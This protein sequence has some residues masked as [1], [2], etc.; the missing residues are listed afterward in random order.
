MR[1]VVTDCGLSFEG[2]WFNSFERTSCFQNVG[3][4]QPDGT[5]LRPTNSKPILQIYIAEPKNSIHYPLLC[6]A[7]ST[8]SSQIISSHNFLYKSDCK[9]KHARKCMN[10]NVHS[11]RN[12]TLRN[13]I[14]NFRNIPS[15]TCNSG[16]SRTSVRV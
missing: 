1:C 14:E 13:N 9:V 4:G 16:I 10:K 2:S 15:R 6:P 12:M 8:S 5:L 11:E 3:N 7:T